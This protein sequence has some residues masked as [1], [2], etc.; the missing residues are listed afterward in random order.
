MWHE[1]TQSAQVTMTTRRMETHTD[2]MR[3]LSTVRPLG[4][5][6]PATCRRNNRT[7]RTVSKKHT[8]QAI[9]SLLR[10]PASMLR[11]RHSRTRRSPTR[12]AS[13]TIR[14]PPIT[15]PTTLKGGP[16]S[17]CRRSSSSSN[18]RRT[19]VRTPRAT[20]AG[21]NLI[22]VR[23]TVAAMGTLSRVGHHTKVA[24]AETLRM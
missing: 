1:L 19:M 2:V 15:R 16:R 18:T 7:L 6:P 11:S 23:G 14:T 21:L 24:E 9:I 12:M 17:R 8:P 5:I 4:V 3:V 10:R 13:S 20:P 22:L